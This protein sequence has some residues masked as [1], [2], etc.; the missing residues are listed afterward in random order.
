MKEEYRNFLDALVRAIPQERIYTDELRTFCWGTDAGFYRM[1]PQIVVRSENEGEVSF[2]LREAS[3]R[4]LPVTFRAAGTALSGQSVSDSI[5]VVAAKNWE[6]FRLCGP[7]S[8]PAEMVALQPGIV[9]AKANA[10]LARYGR[11]LGPDPASIGSAMVG[12]I[13]MNNASGMSCGVHSNSD[14]T[15]V[16]ARIV[17]SDGTVLDTGDAA[18]REAFRRSHG[19]MLKA[20]ADLRDDVL[21]DA[22]LT[23]RIRYKY[24]IKNVTGLNLLPLVTYEDPFDIIAHSIVGSEGTLAFLSSVTLKTVPI[25]P[26]QASAMIYFRDISDAARAVV[27]MRPLSITAAEMLDRRSLAAVGDPTG[28]GLTAILTQVTASSEDELKEKIAAVQAALEPFETVTGVNFSTDADVCARYW[29]IRSG[30]FPMVGGM[31]R[32]GTTCLIEDI[33][34]HIEDLPQATADLSELLDRHGY[35]DSCIYG[36]ALDGNFHFII[37][38]AF[39]SDAEVARYEAMIEDVAKMVVEKYDG[40][41]K[42]EHGTGRNM[43]PFVSYEWGEKAF[44]VMRR[45]KDIFD[46]LGILNPGVIFNDDPRCYL[47]NFKAL[48]VLKPSA[49]AS[50]EMVEAYGRINKCIECG[51]C[52]VNCL[53]HGFAL[54]SRTRIVAQR[55]ITRLRESGEDPKR[56]AALEKQYR[57]YGEEC[58]AGDGLCSTSCPM[59][60]NVADLTHELRREN[61]PVTSASYKAWKAAADH[62]AATKNGIRCVLSLAGAGRAVLGDKAMEK[63]CRA[64]HNTL[65]IPLWTPSTPK[66]YG[67][68]DVRALS[69]TAGVA[70]SV[71]VSSP[72]SAGIAG[73]DVASGAGVAAAAEPLKVVYFP[74][75]LNQMMGVS[76][77]SPALK[78]LAE[79]TVELLHKA[80]YEVVFPE[81][82]DSLCCGTIWE[83]KG[84]PDVAGKKVRELEAALLKASE[85]GRWPVLCDQSPCLH[86]MRLCI[87]GMHLYEPAEFIWKFLRDRLE[88]VPQAEPVAVHQTCTMRLMGLGGTLVELAKLCAPEVIVPEGVGCCGFAGDKGMTTPE[89]NAYALRKLRS[90]VKGVKVGYSNSRTCEIGLQ[91]N[92]GIPYISIVYLVNACTRRK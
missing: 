57:Y 82:M 80:G 72:G 69:G 13:V 36:H 9:G 44:G 79:E 52:E 76:K 51:F 32:Q 35:D 74:S 49:G 58:C 42:A 91:T 53:S 59:K 78:P 46:P 70:G 33:A 89:L 75:C 65:N 88:F 90:E 39:D 34:F 19:A 25:A 26:L 10:K 81:K 83:S 23:E 37:N 55:E 50:A 5:L 16:S 15:L 27:A 30:I 12:G 85:N 29:A 22:E 84:M 28:E 20:V 4:K 71:S 61:H 8:C 14:R 64:L 21:A 67:G 45:L 40:S 31:R 43:A 24:S 18:S 77:G 47:R 7:D 2:I 1:T 66:K 6:G 41:L 17:L 87:K 3:A 11:K 63:V 54:S 48:P 68:P 38:Q 62:F 86:R 60:I 92:S 73:T 56:L